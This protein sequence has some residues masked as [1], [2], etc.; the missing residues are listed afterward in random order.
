MLKMR[1]LDVWIVGVAI[2][3]RGLWIFAIMHEFPSRSPI[4]SMLRNFAVSTTSATTD[5]TLNWIAWALDTLAVPVAAMLCLQ[6]RRTGIL[7]IMNV[8]RSVP[9]YNASSVSAIAVIIA[10]GI[11]RNSIAPL[12]VGFAIAAAVVQNVCFFLKGN[13]G[14][15]SY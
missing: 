12:F 3:L 8:F 14:W 1:T 10:L 4:I 2:A 7:T 13:I 15:I 9:F 11:R 6:N 5:L